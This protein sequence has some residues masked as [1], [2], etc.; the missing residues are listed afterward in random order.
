V[1]SGIEADDRV[2]INPPD[3]ITDGASVRIVER[4]A[5]KP[6]VSGKAT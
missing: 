3:S 2:V 5:E 4:P 6:K 1:L